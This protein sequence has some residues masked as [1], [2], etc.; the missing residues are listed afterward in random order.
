[1]HLLKYCQ[2]FGPYPSDP[3]EGFHLSNKLL[4]SLTRF[5][6]CC[7]SFTG[8]KGQPCVWCRLHGGHSRPHRSQFFFGETWPGDW[9]FE[10]IEGDIVR[11]TQLLISIIGFLRG[12]YLLHM[13]LNDQTYCLKGKWIMAISP[14]HNLIEYCSSGTFSVYFN[15]CLHLKYLLK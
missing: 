4:F 5:T 11:Q 6:K 12:R 9:H 8:Y 1:M 10:P 7:P 14:N 15:K 3:K 13:E 2:L